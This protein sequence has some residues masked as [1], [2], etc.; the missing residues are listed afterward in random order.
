M[1]AGTAPRSSPR[2]NAA[3]PS[4]KPAISD[5]P[6]G[7]YERIAKFLCFLFAPTLGYA[8]SRSVDGWSRHQPW[9][10]TM[11][12]IRY[13]LGMTA[14]VLGGIAGYWALTWFFKVLRPLFPR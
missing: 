10:E 11:P 12:W 2:S 7:R 5:A 1:A 14:L 4:G 13:G 6:G 8:L 9:A 3:S